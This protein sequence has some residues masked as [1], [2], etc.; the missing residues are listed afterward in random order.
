MAMSK[1]ESEPMPGGWS[2][3]V[4]ALVARICYRR[5]R[6]G[7]LS[8]VVGVVDLTNSD[9][10]ARYLDNLDSPRA[11]SATEAGL[12][13]AVEDSAALWHRSVAAWRRRPRDGPGAG[14]LPAAS[15][16]EPAPDGGPAEAPG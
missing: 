4:E 5:E 11:A 8:E 6:G 10:V 7:T 1:S 13:L 3:Q 16:P 9:S 12:R 14:V 2:L 15:A